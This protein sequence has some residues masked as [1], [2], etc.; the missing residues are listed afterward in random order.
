MF[1]K[2]RAACFAQAQFAMSNFALNNL[3]RGKSK[4]PEKP[5]FTDSIFFFFYNTYFATVKISQAHELE[6]GGSSTEWK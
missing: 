1:S 6:T 4:Q 3:E 2:G 5:L